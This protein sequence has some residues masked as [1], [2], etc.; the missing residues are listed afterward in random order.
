MGPRPKAEVYHHHRLARRHV[1]PEISLVFG[2]ADYRQDNLD[3]VHAV[4]HTFTLTLRILV[5]AP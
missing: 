1:S 5:Q 3:G 4:C 2:R